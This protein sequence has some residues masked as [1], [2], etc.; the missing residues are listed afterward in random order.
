MEEKE[1]KKKNRW[2]PI[3]GFI[4]G[5]FTLIIGS[6]TLFYSIGVRQCPVSEEYAKLEKEC[7]KLERECA[8]LERACNKL[9]TIIE[10]LRDSIEILKVGEV[11]ERKT[12]DVNI[13]NSIFKKQIEVLI[14]QGKNLLKNYDEQINMTYKFNSWK[15]NVI[16]IVKN[17]DKDIEK[18]INEIESKYSTGDYFSPIRDIIDLLERYKLTY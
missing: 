5:L 13:A 6:S 10:T 15:S 9:E 3:L 4:I 11:I 16:G 17:R 18:K 2:L 7:A 12:N 8:K 14:E 1:N